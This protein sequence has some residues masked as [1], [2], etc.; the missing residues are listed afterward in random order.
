MKY[1]SKQ[2]QT[3]DTNLMGL[4][5]D[6]CDSCNALGF[7][8]TL[9]DNNMLCNN[10]YYN[11]DIC[12]CE[13]CGREITTFDYNDYGGLCGYCYNGVEIYECNQCGREFTASNDILDFYCND[14][15]NS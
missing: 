6:R 13:D 7:G 5:V 8:K 1:K 4:L 3:W 9:M 12:K 14:C 2:G 15:L 10:C 11:K